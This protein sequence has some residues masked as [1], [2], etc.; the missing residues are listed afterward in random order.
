PTTS[1]A[2]TSEGDMNMA[3][4][5]RNPANMTSQIQ[6]LAP[7]SPLLP[8]A[9]PV[10]MYDVSPFQYCIAGDNIVVLA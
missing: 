5:Q 10:A 4:S 2:G 1:A 8:M 3:S 9:S 6:H 7:G